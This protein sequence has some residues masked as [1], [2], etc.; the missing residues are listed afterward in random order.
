MREALISM[1]GPEGWKSYGVTLTI[2]GPVLT[3]DQSKTLWHNYSRLIDRADMCAIWRVEIQERGALHWHLILWSR[4]MVSISMQEWARKQTVPA[5]FAIE[6]IWHECIRGLGEIK[7]DDPYYGKNGDWKQGILRSNS[8]MGLPGAVWRACKVETG[9][10]ESGSWL[11]YLQDHATKAKQ[12]QIPENIGRH[13]GIIGR[14]RFKKLAPSGIEKLTDAQFNI[15]IRAYQRLCTPM[16]K[17]PKNIFGSV[18]G[19][20]VRRG[21]MGSSVWF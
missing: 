5:Q 2:P 14:K 20:R 3:A 16:M 19:Y 1:T 6:H 21:S 8:R 11:R 18:L 10:A 17:Q 4:P 12:E 9:E 7:F 13:W 15:F